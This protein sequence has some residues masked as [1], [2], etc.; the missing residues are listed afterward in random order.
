MNVDFGA[1]SFHVVEFAT[2]FIQKYHKNPNFVDQFF[3]WFGQHERE[4][5]AKTANIVMSDCPTFLS[6]IYML[7]MQKPEFC[8]ESALSLSKMYKRVLFDLFS[9]TDLIF[10][11]IVDYK[12]NNVRYQS[13]EEAL[14]IERRIRQFLADHHI[15]HCVAAYD[16]DILSEL[17]YINR[18]EVQRSRHL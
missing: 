7:Q 17:F 8:V 9:Y 10:I 2:S 13:K 12:D 14:E 1:N 5:N 16:D 3:V 18:Q 11:P 4:E 6:Y 15:K